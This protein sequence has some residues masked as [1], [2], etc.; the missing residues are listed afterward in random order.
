M[1]EQVKSPTGPCHVALLI[2]L[3]GGVRQGPTNMTGGTSTH[4]L[5]N[6]GIDLYLSKHVHFGKLQVTNII[7]HSENRLLH[8]MCTTDK[9]N[10]SNFG[11]FIILE[12]ILL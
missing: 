2:L 3:P 10:C 7:L 8:V 11:T 9:K 4:W 5:R 6:T 1:V 12:S